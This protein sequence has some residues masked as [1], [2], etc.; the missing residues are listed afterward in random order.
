MAHAIKNAQSRVELMPVVNCSSGMGVTFRNFLV[1][2]GSVSHESECSMSRELYW[3]EQ[4]RFRFL[5]FSSA[6][7]LLI[8]WGEPVQLVQPVASGSVVTLQWNGLHSVEFDGLYFHSR[9]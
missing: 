9:K 8:L 1:I 7:C 2:I 5:I 6:V 3:P 4:P